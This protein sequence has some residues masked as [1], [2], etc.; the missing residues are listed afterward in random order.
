MGES[1]QCERSGAPPHQFLIT[2]LHDITLTTVLSMY[3]SKTRINHQ[4]LYLMLMKYCYATKR[5]T[6][7]MQR[8]ESY[9]HT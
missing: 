2:P 8:C 1:Q 4:H 5:K 7:D 6:T 9:R 3:N